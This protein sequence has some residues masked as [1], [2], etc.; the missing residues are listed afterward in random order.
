[1]KIGILLCGQ[2]ADEIVARHGDYT[3]LY[4]GMLAD[5]GF[6]FVVF[7]A[8]NMEFPQS[9]ADADGWLLT[10]SRFGAYDDLPF[11]KPLEE[12]IRTAY[13]DEVP[14]VGICFGHQI[15][16]QA[17]GGKVTKFD[18]GWEIGPKTYNFDDLGPVVLNAWHQDQVVDLPKDAKV[19]ASGDSCENAAL[20]F[21]NRAL[22]IQAHPEFSNMV[23]RD[24]VELRRDL[25]EYPK[26]V[27]TNA[28]KNLSIANDNK[29]MAD[30]IAGFFKRSQGDVDA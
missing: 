1:M 11:I 29:K 8:I 23:V 2:A 15:I 5:H 9:T 10:G 17:L 21:G 25:P 20:V 22:T 12:F 13:A 7:D 30:R 18:G 19:I 24:Y 27:M 16:A 3:K 28:W 26:D 4:S 14:M 6:E